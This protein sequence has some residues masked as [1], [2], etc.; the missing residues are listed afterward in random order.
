M[1]QERFLETG[2]DAPMM[3]FFQNSW[4]RDGKNNSVQ[5]VSADCEGR[6]EGGV[7]IRE[8]T[9]FNHGVFLSLEWCTRRRLNARM[10]AE[11]SNPDPASGEDN[12][13]EAVNSLK[14]A[15]PV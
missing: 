10:I 9:F 12:F 3:S 4:Y 13:R 6:Q 15:R 1:A 7:S 11:A 14:D 5:M 2:Q 8:A